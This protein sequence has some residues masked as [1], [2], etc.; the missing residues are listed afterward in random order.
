VNLQEFLKRYPASILFKWL[1]IQER[2]HFRRLERKATKN[3]WPARAAQLLR[4]M[5]ETEIEEVRKLA[6][7]LS[8]N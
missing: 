4:K 1:R 2:A 7:K 8:R 3:T 5:S 6:T